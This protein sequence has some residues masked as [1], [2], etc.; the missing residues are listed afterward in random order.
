MTSPKDCKASC[1]ILQ[2]LCEKQHHNLAYLQNY[3]I[4]TWL[5][6]SAGNVL[7]FDSAAR[8]NTDY[9][10]FDF[11]RQSYGKLGEMYSHAGSTV[12]LIEL[13]Y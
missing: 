12:P 2:E 5:Q 9:C 3:G 13:L 4:S 11:A 1:V 7:P 6:Q 8:P 10:Y